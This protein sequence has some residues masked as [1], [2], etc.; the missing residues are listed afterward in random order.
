MPPLPGPQSRL[1][2]PTIQWMLRASP[3]W[4]GSTELGAGGG[5]DRGEASPK[6]CPGLQCPLG[7]VPWPPKGGLG[8]PKGGQ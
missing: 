2:W 3:G 6:R 1:D 8:H 7:D 5:F 4:G